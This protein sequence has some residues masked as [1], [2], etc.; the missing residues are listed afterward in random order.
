MEKEQFNVVKFK[1]VPGEGNNVGCIE[2][3]NVGI[4]EGNVDGFLIGFFLMGFLS[5]EYLGGKLDLML[6]PV[7]AAER[8]L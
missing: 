4:E 7:V 1:S 2:G 3:E 5:A 6:G 8:G